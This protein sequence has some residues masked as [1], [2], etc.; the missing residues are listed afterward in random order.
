MKTILLLALLGLGWLLMAAQTSYVWTVDPNG[1]GTFNGNLTVNG[2]LQ[3]AGPWAVSSP[4]PG[5]AFAASAGGSSSFGVSNDGNFYV[6]N[7]GA[8]PAR[9]L[10]GEG[11]AKVATSGSYT[12]LTNQPAIP[13]GQM[14]AD[15]N[16]TGGMAMVLNKPLMVAVGG[17]IT[18]TLVCLPEAGHTISSGFSTSCAFTVTAIKP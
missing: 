12:D 15:W 1:N 11:L 7:G 13:A 2:Q 9:V 17:S 6:S 10:T 18:G 5:A 8:P 14:N 3:V 16:A 4:I